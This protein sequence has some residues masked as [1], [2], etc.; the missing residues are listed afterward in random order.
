MLTTRADHQDLIG[1][2]LMRV[3]TGAVGLA[4]VL[5]SL[6]SPVVITG[7]GAT[8]AVWD[9]HHTADVHC[10]KLSQSR[11]ACAIGYDRNPSLPDE[12]CDHDEFCG[13]ESL[14]PTESFGA[15]T[16]NSRAELTSRVPGDLF[17]DS[18]LMMLGSPGT[19]RW[20]SMGLAR[21]WG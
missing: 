14:T 10:P 3:A 21:R 12:V 11:Y 4:A 2:P 20:R 16:C 15:T 8:M 5:G 18:F 1:S 13:V 6:T 7:I 19:S 9:A 17:R